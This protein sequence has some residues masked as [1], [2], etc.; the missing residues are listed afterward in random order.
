MIIPYR[1]QITL[2][3]CKVVSKPLLTTVFA[4]HF[5]MERVQSHHLY[6]QT[7]LYTPLTSTTYIHTITNIT[8]IYIQL[9][10]FTS[11]CIVYLHYNYPSSSFPAIS[12][13]KNKKEKLENTT[14]LWK[15]IVLTPSHWI[16][17]TTGMIL[18]IHHFKGANTKC[19]WIHITKAGVTTLRGILGIWGFLGHPG[20]IPPTRCFRYMLKI[21]KQNLRR[22]PW[23]SRVGILPLSRLLVSSRMFIIVYVF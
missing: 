9:Q 21:K 13:L 4:T 1:K 14:R 3:H 17:S 22:W 8:T 2:F 19:V 10:P 23:M 16:C 5:Q 11:I 7:I 18:T 12:T 6:K 15:F 20:T